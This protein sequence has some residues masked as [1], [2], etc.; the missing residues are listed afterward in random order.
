MSLTCI[1]KREKNIQKMTLGKMSLNISNLV[2]TEE[3]LNG[4]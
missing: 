4:M 2:S 3:L 1:E